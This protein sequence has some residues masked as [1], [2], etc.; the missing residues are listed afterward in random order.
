MAKTLARRGIHDVQTARAFLDPRHYQPAPAGDLPD[1]EEAAERLL[2]ASHRGER[3]CVWGD[4]DVD[5]QTATSLLV[6]A[7]GELI[8]QMAYYIPNRL[9]ESHGVNVSRL[10]ELIDRGMDVLLT[11]DTGVS[12]HAAIA[13]ART[14]GVDVIVTDHHALPDTLPNAHAVINPKRLPPNH[15][16][17][18]MAGVG[19]A[20]K[21]VE[22]LYAGRDTARFLDL[23][24]L[25]TVADVMVLCDD[26]RYMVQ[27][28][29]AAMRHT[30]RLGLQA[31]FESAEIIPDQL[32]ENTIGFSIAPR[33]NALGR[34]D[35]ANKAV[36]LLTTD[37]PARARM[38]ASEL[39]GLNAQRK[40]RT[41]QVYRA[42]LAEIERNRALLDYAA[43]V[44]AHSA[45]PAGIIGIVA[46]RLAER[47]NRPVV[48]LA[49]PESKPARG[50]ARS[51]PGCDITAAIA[52]QQAMLH[53][54]GGHQ[55]AAGLSID[56]K[57][58]DNFR[59][60]LSR[61]VESM[62]G[63]VATRKRLVIDEYVP[64]GA[65]TLDF[66][67]DLERL[68]PFGPGNPELTLAAHDVTVANVRSV[69]RT[70]QHRRLVV[71][72]GAGSTQEVMWWRSA[73][74]PIPEGRFDLAYRARAGDFQGR[75]RVEVMW[76]DARQEDSAV[77]VQREPAP[78]EIV[79]YRGID[80]PQTTLVE[81]KTVGN[82]AVWAEG[83]ASSV[84]LPRDA[85]SS[86]ERLAI[87]T[88][89]PSPAELHA[90]LKLVAP[91]TVYI[92]GIDPA[93]SDIK[94]F[95]RRLAGL[96]RYAL[97]EHESLVSLE[98]LA[99]ATAQRT[100][101]VRAGI[102]WLEAHGD[103]T[104]MEEEAGMLHLATSDGQ[105]RANLSQTAAR[106][107]AWLEETTAYRAHFARIDTGALHLA[108]TQA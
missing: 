64:L 103:I 73:D 46:N 92:F 95:I 83:D 37:D 86:A 17:Y 85:L 80:K 61:T 30:D 5:G 70:G 60:A 69:G 81:L 104:V 91:E 101:T 7:L 98:K 14:R 11:C 31:L 52:Q 94:S 44:I 28:G 36:E 45:W 19:C 39:E 74:L 97:R 32:N 15:P 16:L 34:L 53:G 13:Y 4:F 23:V 42:A 38:L 25:G 33:L 90:V 12:A 51:V 93:P 43:L 84:G 41:D 65:L 105:P 8:P 55:M 6:S 87:W 100:D 3:V 89:P 59:R 88:T 1:I 26:N 76:V 22:A 99:A 9:R 63:E 27:R 75:R 20:Y 96:I 57:Q 79:D 56:P 49:A 50:S 35:D 71:T 108:L 10:T 66:V 29:L 107:Q 24:A 48:L 21:L 18:E 54:F 77:S 58:I 82:I 72:D 67:A 102:A 62:L 47:Y 68:A 2:R 78:M 106:L 40:Q